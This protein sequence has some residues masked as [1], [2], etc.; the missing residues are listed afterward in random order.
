MIHETFVFPKNAFHQYLPF[1]YQKTFD[2]AFPTK[3]DEEFHPKGRSAP[4]VHRLTM[5]NR[6][7]IADGLEYPR[8][9][10]APKQNNTV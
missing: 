4:N 5:V 7:N 2:F 1:K 6:L 8:P 10:K 9:C 3:S